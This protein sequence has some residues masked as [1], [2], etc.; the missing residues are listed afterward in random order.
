MIIIFFQLVLLLQCFSACFCF[1]N[2]SQLVLLLQCFS[3]CFCFFNASSQLVFED[4][5]GHHK[6]AGPWQ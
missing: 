4:K 6:H 3:A 5:Q 1:F 2:A